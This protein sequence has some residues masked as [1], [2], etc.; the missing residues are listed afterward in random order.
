MNELNEAIEGLKEA[1]STL[2]VAVAEAL[3][4]IQVWMQEFTNWLIATLDMVI[5]T[6]EDIY[7]MLSMR[8]LVDIMRET[9][10]RK[11]MNRYLRYKGINKKNAK[12]TY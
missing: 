7:F 1:W 6:L 4:P 3:K 2:A 10:M 12:N 5:A 11:K 9:I 8:K